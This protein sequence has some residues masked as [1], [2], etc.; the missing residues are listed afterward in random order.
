LALPEPVVS[1][2]VCHMASEWLAS[3]CGR[4]TLFAPLSEKKH[5]LTIFHYI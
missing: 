2:P 4:M 3:T 1:H 5:A